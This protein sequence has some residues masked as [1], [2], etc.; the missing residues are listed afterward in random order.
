VKIYPHNITCF[1]KLAS[2]VGNL[3]GHLLVD[4]NIHVSL[5]DEGIRRYE[6]AVAL[7]LVNQCLEQ[8]V[9]LD[10]LLEKVL[11]ILAPISVQACNALANLATSRKDTA[12]LK[13]LA[14]NKGE[15]ERMAELT[16]L[17]WI[18]LFETFPSLS[19]QVT[20]KF[21]LCNMKAN[22]PRSYSIASCKDTVGSEMHLCIGRFLYSR[23][24]SK[25]EAGICSD[26]LTSINAGD[27][28][29]F[30]LES[31]PGFHYPKDPA[32][33]IILICTGTG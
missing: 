4:D 26:F 7:P 17:K 18:D 15:Y 8:L 14:E 13:S 19:R 21:L 3:A 1:K 16:G 20:I 12:V 11:G 22:H 10:Y 23:G 9:P 29:L 6:I 27:E 28:V 30:K 25:M 5:R 31:A 33:P 32:S 24:G 2:F